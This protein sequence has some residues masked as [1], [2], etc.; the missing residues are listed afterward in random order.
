MPLAVD[1]PPRCPR[2]GGTTRPNVL[3]FY[4]FWW[5]S[6]RM[7]ARRDAMDEW[8]AG[9]PDDAR[10]VVIELGAGVAVPSVRVCGEQIARSRGGRL[11]RI[12]PK[13]SQCEDLSISLGALEALE[14]LDRLISSRSRA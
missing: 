14:S 3:L 4:D 1:P 11:I 10:V 5:L 13:E 9:L 12:N 7:N 6:A 8:L 2:C